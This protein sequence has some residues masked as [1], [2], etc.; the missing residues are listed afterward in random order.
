[1]TTQE[2]AFDQVMSILFKSVGSDQ[3]RLTEE[4]IALVRSL[5]AFEL[6]TMRRRCMRRAKEWKRVANLFLEVAMGRGAQ[7]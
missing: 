7:N 2:R 4:E 3:L 1:M 5:N 6:S